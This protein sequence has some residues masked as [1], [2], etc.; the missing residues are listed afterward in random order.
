[1]VIGGRRVGSRAVY[2]S[3]RRKSCHEGGYSCHLKF[4]SLESTITEEAVMEAW[5]SYSHLPT[6]ILRELEIIGLCP[7]T[8]LQLSG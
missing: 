4:A 5:V 6:T 3:Y 8:R 7:K 1:M 2:F